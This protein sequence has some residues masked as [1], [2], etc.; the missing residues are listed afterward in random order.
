V[1]AMPWQSAL[2]FVGAGAILAALLWLGITD[3]LRA[4]KR[5]IRRAKRKS[6]RRV[7]KIRASLKELNHLR[8]GCFTVREFNEW[9]RR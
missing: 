6:L 2:S 7:R 4:E 8:P 3:P 5:Q 1:S 9:T